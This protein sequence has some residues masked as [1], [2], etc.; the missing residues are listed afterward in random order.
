MQYDLETM[1]Y[2]DEFYG[3]SVSVHAGLSNPAADRRGAGVQLSL[4][5]EPLGVVT[6]IIHQ[7][8][9]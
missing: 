9:R 5:H 4:E 2:S 3:D 6:S 7:Y 8:H 1:A